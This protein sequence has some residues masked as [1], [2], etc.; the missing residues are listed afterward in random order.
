MASLED[1]S[2]DTRNNLEEL[3][4]DAIDLQNIQQEEGLKKE[5]ESLPER[6]EAE[7]FVTLNKD[8]PPLLEKEKEE[9]NEP[10]RATTNLSD[11]NRMK[12]EQQ[13]DASPEGISMDV[14]THEISPQAPVAPV[15]PTPSGD[16]EKHDDNSNKE[17]VNY[18]THSSHSSSS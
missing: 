9:E 1:P 13:K 15:A 11:G 5:P 7:A 4:Q 3:N 16:I 12:E 14:Q 10:E 6:P 8:T 18:K 2:S 17:N